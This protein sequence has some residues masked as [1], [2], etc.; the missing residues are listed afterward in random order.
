MKVMDNSFLVALINQIYEME[1][2]LGEL[3][4]DALDRNL[5][6]LNNLIEENGFVVRNPLGE[7]YNETRTDYEAN[8]VGII[9]KHM[10]ITKVIK[11]IIYQKSNDGLQLL[12]K[13]IVIAEN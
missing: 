6:K 12:Q 11:P 3:S 7:T 10:K 4:I 1:T 5:R 2:K 8:L 13:A 9:S